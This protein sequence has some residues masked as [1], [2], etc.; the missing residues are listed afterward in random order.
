MRCSPLTLTGPPPAFSLMVTGAF[1]SNS[2]R[3]T[4]RVE[5]RLPNHTGHISN[6]RVGEV[7]VFVPSADSWR[8]GW[9]LALKWSFPGGSWPSPP[10][11]CS[12]PW[13]LLPGK[14][15]KHQSVVWLI[16]Q[17]VGNLT[18]SSQRKIFR[19][20]HTDWTKSKCTH[21]SEFQ[22][23]LQVLLLVSLESVERHFGGQFTAWN[24]D[25]YKSLLNSRFYVHD[26]TKIG[27]F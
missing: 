14:S 16:S 10:R 6:R 26:Q 22:E 20:V 27:G 2:P 17:W 3:L 15:T 19:K 12:P 13:H 18:D 23:M 5:E 21:C 4:W 7:L 9:R 11:R 24:V 8:E 25:T 1:S